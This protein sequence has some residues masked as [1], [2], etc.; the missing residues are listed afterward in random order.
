[1]AENIS[2]RVK[3]M[4]ED[5]GVY[6]CPICGKPV[7]HIN[8]PAFPFCSPTCRLVDLNKWL[9]GSYGASRP[10]DPSDELGDMPA[11]PPL[12]RPVCED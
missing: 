2:R 10:L 4:G 8:V 12:R 1:M 11:A 9:E 7:A 6:K 5:G 3:P